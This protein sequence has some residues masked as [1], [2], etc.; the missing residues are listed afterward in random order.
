MGELKMF[1]GKWD[2]SLFIHVLK[3]FIFTSCEPTFRFNRFQCWRK[4]AKDLSRLRFRI[5]KPSEQVTVPVPWR[6]D[7]VVSMESSHIGWCSLFW[8]QNRNHSWRAVEVAW[9]F[10]SFPPFPLFLKHLPCECP[11]AAS[12]QAFSQLAPPSPLSTSGS[13]ARACPRSGRPVQ[14]GCCW[15]LS[16]AKPIDLEGG[17]R[18]L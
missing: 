9:F 13:H 4:Q 2:L 15:G 10:T 1:K 12:P 18:F 7:G 8:S 14:E 6:W 3:I 17:F 11:S 5:L 16:C